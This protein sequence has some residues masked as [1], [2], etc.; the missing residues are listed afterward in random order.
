MEVLAIDL[1]E[2]MPQ[3]MV[4]S[5]PR[6][7]RPDPKDIQEDRLV[8]LVNHLHGSESLRQEEQPHWQILEITERDYLKM[9]GVKDCLV[10]QVGGREAVPGL[11]NDAVPVQTSHADSR[12]WRGVTAGRVIFDVSLPWAARAQMVHVQE[13]SVGDR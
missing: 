13:H 6:R 10:S 12:T 9:K 11:S 8:L 3:M 4:P 5:K 1:Y 7:L 2:D